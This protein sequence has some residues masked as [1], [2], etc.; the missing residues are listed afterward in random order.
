MKTLKWTIPLGLDTGKPCPSWLSI[1]TNLSIPRKTF[2][3]P[4]AKQRRERYERD[5]PRSLLHLCLQVSEAVWH[6]IHCHMHSDCFLNDISERNS[7][8][9]PP[10]GPLF[11]G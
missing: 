1:L 10:P 11:L 6:F 2:R 8:L 4:L 7:R 5:G 9:C 3:K